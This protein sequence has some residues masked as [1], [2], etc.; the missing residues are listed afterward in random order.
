M[1][2][3]TDDDGEKNMNIT[4]LLPGGSAR[5]AFFLFPPIDRP[6][7]FCVGGEKA[8]K[9]SSKHHINVI[10]ASNN[11]VTLIICAVT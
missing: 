6:V 2:F 7:T 8:H 4:Q 10:F 9:M 11:V 1:Y 3:T 5:G